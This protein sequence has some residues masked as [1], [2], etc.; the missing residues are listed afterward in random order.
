MDEYIHVGLTEDR[1][2]QAIYAF[3]CHQLNTI[4]GGFGVSFDQLIQQLPLQSFFQICVIT[5]F[6]QLSG[7]E[8]TLFLGSI[9]V[10]EILQNNL[11]T[12][13]IL[14]FPIH[15]LSQNIGVFIVQKRFGLKRSKCY[16]DG[17]KMNRRVRKGHHRMWISHKKFMDWKVF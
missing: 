4:N 17:L 10:S 15:S 13:E 2:L 14:W 3:R 1:K 5:E 8:K 6:F 12:S 7:M 9:S 11:Q 16:E